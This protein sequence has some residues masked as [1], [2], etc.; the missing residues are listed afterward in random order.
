MVLFLILG[1]G[2]WFSTLFLSFPLALSLCNYAVG[3]CDSETFGGGIRVEESS[4][5]VWVR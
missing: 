3:M 2:V 5:L 4:L 1:C